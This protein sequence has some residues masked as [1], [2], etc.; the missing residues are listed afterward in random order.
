MIYFEI[1]DSSAEALSALAKAHGATEYVVWFYPEHRDKQPESPI[2]KSEREAVTEYEDECGPHFVT[3]RGIDAFSEFLQAYPSRKKFIDSITFYANGQ[4]EWMLSA[5]FHEH[6]AILR[7][8]DGRSCKEL[9]FYPMS[10]A[11]DHW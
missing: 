5:I 6:M 9:G 3:A 7:S 1:S 10:Q 2:K 8:E 11:P 4:K